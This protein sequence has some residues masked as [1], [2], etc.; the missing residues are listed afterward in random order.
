MKRISRIRKFRKDILAIAGSL[1]KLLFDIY[2][3]LLYKVSSKRKILFNVVRENQFEMCAPIYHKLRND[4]RLR[5]YFTSALCHNYYKR[6]KRTMGW[7]GRFKAVALSKQPALRLLAPYI[8]SSGILSDQ[9]VRW[10]RWDV[11][12]EVQ[13]HSPKIKLPTKWI[14]M[15]HG[16]AGKLTPDGENY[17]VNKRAGKYDRLFCFSPKLVE[18]Y[19]Q[20]GYI[21]DEKAALCIGFPK[22]DG[23]VDGNITRDKVLQSYGADPSQMSVLYAPSWNPEL[24]LNNIGEELIELLSN[25][26]WTFLVKL[27]PISYQFVRRVEGY[28]RGDWDRFLDAQA[29]QGGLI[30]VRD[31]YSP[32]YLKAADVLITDHGST[33]YEYMLLNRPVLYY[34]APEAGSV[35]AMPETLPRIRR[36]TRTFQRPQ[37]ALDLLSTGGFADTAGMAE[38]RQQL[39][40]ERFYDVGGATE[41]AVK[42]I[43]ELIGL[44][45]P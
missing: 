23:L 14:Q 19:I 35:M 45:P 12:I 27:H 16:F 7:L 8:D 40:Q 5:I 11:C 36:A 28:T 38:A 43:Y 1:I 30:Y 2:R 13:Y 22:L 34:D 33:L 42:A 15:F 41:R 21:K 37:Q 25:R 10:R 44:E 4:P 24:S 3:A 32:R 39:A 31:Q 29:A 17:T 9:Q 20:S 18:H 26:Q 6:L